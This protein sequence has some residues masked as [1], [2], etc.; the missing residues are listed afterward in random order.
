MIRLTRWAVLGGETRRVRC[1]TKG[2]GADE[3]MQWRLRL[4]MVHLPS[5][6]SLSVAAVGC[7]YGGGANGTSCG[8]AP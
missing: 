5:G 2:G 8:H 6:G 4:T 3:H 7:G 1:S